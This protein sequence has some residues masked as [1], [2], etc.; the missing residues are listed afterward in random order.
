MMGKE[1]VLCVRSTVD[2]Q[3]GRFGMLGEE[4]V[5]CARSTV[6]S[7]SPG[8]TL[9][10]GYGWLVSRPPSEGGAVLVLCPVKCHRRRGY[11]HVLVRNHV[12]PQEGLSRLIP[13]MRVL[14]AGSC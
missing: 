2:L 5:L 11:L 9:A 4:P 13:L 7:P 6:D 1:P 8:R 12:L 3:S 10:R 14:E